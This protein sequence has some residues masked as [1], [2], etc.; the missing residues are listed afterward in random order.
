[1]QTVTVSGRVAA[2]AGGVVSFPDMAPADIQSTRATGTVVWARRGTSRNRDDVP[3]LLADARSNSLIVD[4][5]GL[6]DGNGNGPQDVYPIVYAYDELDVFAVEGVMVDMN[7]FEE[8]LI[9]PLVNIPGPDDPDAA[10]ADL[11]RIDHSRDR[12][13]TWRLWSDLQ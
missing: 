6:D 11:G 9:S 13:A 7:Q 5:Q 10:H 4:E 8:I 1:M 2:I 3:V 12:S